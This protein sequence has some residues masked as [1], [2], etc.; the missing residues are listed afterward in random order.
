MQIPLLSRTYRAQLEKRLAKLSDI[1]IWHKN[2]DFHA[3]YAVSVNVR[4]RNDFQRTI[5]ID[6]YL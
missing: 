1:P 6:T 4:G 5:S 2:W 3:A